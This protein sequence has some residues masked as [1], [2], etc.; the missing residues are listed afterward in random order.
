LGLIGFVLLGWV[1]ARRDATWMLLTDAGA[2]LGGAVVLLG[3]LAVF[4]KAESGVGAAEP[5]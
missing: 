3:L 1:S 4:G 2:G 5:G